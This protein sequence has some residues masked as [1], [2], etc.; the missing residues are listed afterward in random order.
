MLAQLLALFGLA[1]LLRLARFLLCLRGTHL[2]SGFPPLRQ[3][4]RAA[5]RARPPDVPCAV[6][7]VTT[8][9][10]GRRRREAIGWARVGSR[11]GERGSRA[12]LGMGIAEEGAGADGMCEVDAPGDVPS[13]HGRRAWGARVHLPLNLR[14][15]L[16]GHH[17]G[18][19]GGHVLHDR[20]FAYLRAHAM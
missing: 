13:C 2:G 9:G 7:C 1:P 17:C 15:L 14:L 4:R 19:D 5:R 10:A 18:G 20:D 3:R 6:V 11:S 8:A 16:V 12:S